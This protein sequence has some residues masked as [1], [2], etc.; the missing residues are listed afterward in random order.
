MILAYV[1]SCLLLVLAFERLRI[2]AL[3]RAMGRTARAAFGTI[4]DRA[5]S[6]DEKELALRK[7]S[8]ELLHRTTI[9]TLALALL[10][11][12]AALPVVLAERAGWLTY[13]SFLL[14]SIQ[15]VVVIG[16]IAALGLLPVLGRLAR[17]S[18]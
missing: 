5:M 18:H 17:K 1:A 14:F 12:L 15:P 7:D 13:Q 10:F 2:V 8:L 9:L 3:T 16:T 11:A 6:D 4:A